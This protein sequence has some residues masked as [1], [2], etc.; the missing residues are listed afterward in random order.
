MS[1]Y[2]LSQCHCNG[3]Y[4]SVNCKEYC[5]NKKLSSCANQLSARLPAPGVEHVLSLDEFQKQC[6]QCCENKF[7]VIPEHHSST[8]MAPSD[9]PAHF[10]SHHAKLYGQVQQC[11]TFC[12]FDLGLT[13]TGCGNQEYGGQDLKYGLSDPIGRVKNEFPEQSPFFKM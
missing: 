13:H 2:D 12:N 7:N 3:S 5:Q 1:N 8:S 11:Q 10:P 9:H 4:E 6:F